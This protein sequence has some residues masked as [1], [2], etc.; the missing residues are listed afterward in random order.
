[1]KIVFGTYLDNHAEIKYPIKF[2]L[3]ELPQLQLF[4]SDEQE[5]DILRHEL[6][7]VNVKIINQKIKLPG[8]I[9]LAQNTCLDLLFAKGADYVVWVQADMHLLPEFFELIHGICVPSNLT[10]SWGVNI[11]HLRL[12]HIS[13]IGSFGVSI[14]GK[15]CPNRFVG[16]GAYL[17]QAGSPI[18][19][20]KPVAVDLGYLGITQ[21]K[22]HLRQHGKTWSSNNDNYLLPDE[23]FTINFLDYVDSSI[24]LYDFISQDSPYYKF[25]ER[26][27]LA[28]EYN[29]VKQWTH[30]K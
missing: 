15:D 12:F 5:R 26:F 8:D 6:G 7:D 11:Q 1:M 10:G 17:G 3:S 4:C 14:I 24:G 25:V 18:A 28:E 9:A 21:C 23:E 22:D 19:G 16:D 30:Q 20:N 2:L 27:G 29:K 13:V